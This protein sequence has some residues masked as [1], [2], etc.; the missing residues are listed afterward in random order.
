MTRTQHFGGLHEDV[1]EAVNLGYLYERADCRPRVIERAA[2]ALRS[3][4][5]EL[6][7]CA[8]VDTVAARRQLDKLGE[9]A[10]VVA[11]NMR[12][13]VETRQRALKNQA[14]VR[15]YPDLDSLLL[16][17]GSGIELTRKRRARAD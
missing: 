1:C 7:L 2:V 3:R 13:P 10:I 4:T 17:V 9:R 14:F 15:D 12:Q 11:D 8:A 5:G 16:D 6:Q